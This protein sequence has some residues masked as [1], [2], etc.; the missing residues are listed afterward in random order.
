MAIDYDGGLTCSMGVTD[1]D[2]GIAWYRDVLG[3]ELL[4]RLEDIAWCELKTGVERVNIGLGVRE[5]YLVPI[6][7]RRVLLRI[8]ANLHQIYLQLSENDEATRVQR[9][10]VALAK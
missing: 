8:C 7:A 6:S 3:F 1:L 2:R 9:Y 4:Y 5:G 10:L